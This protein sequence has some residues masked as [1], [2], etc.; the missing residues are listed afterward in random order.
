MDAI[1]RHHNEPPL[2]DRLALDHAELVKRAT[3]AAALVPADLRAV[4]SDEE[5]E[6]YTQTASDIKDVIADAD[7]V[8]TVEKKPW[9]DGG[10]AVDDFFRFRA[11]LKAAAQRAVDAINAY[12]RAQLAAKRKAEA[13]AAE[14]A[15][16]EATPFDDEP[17]A[18][19]TPVVAKEAVRI[20]TSVGTK[21]SGT[22]KWKGRVV[23]FAQLPDQYK[24]VNETALNA[25][26]AGLKAQ[27]G[28]IENAKIPGVEI[29]EDIQT[30]IRR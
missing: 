7:K 30:S 3:E 28:K 6:A 29:Y 2:A 11:T 4:E 26:V 15:R 23:D 17:V 27:G 8:F 21:A 13:E 5:V 14:K 16:Q 19:P 22:L 20:V 25:A 1:T 18:A 9:L 24:L 12:Q 10:K